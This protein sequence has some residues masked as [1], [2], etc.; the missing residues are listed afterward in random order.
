MSRKTPRR[1]SLSLSLS[2]FLSLSL[3]LSP[4]LTHRHTHTLSVTPTRICAN[5]HPAVIS[6]TAACLGYVMGPR[7]DR[8]SQHGHGTSRCV[9]VCLA[10]ARDPHFPCI[11]ASGYVCTSVGAHPFGALCPMVCFFFGC[12]SICSCGRKTWF[13]L[14]GSSHIVSISCGVPLLHLISPRWLEQM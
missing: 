8:G 3:S 4:P 14:L 12:W 7:D 10:R 13:L 5:S 6:C 9:P 2:L 1:L 11:R